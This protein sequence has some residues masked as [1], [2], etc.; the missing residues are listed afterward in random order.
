MVSSYSVSFTAYKT[1]TI[2]FIRNQLLS[3]S[4]RSVPFIQTKRL[5]GVCCIL[6]NIYIYI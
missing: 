1:R 5:N 4:E 2:K 3:K 6:V